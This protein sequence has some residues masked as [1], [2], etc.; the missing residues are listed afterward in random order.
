MHSGKIWALAFQVQD[1]WLD[2]FGDRP[3]FGKQNG[4]DILANKKTFLLV[5]ALTKRR[6][7]ERINPEI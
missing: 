4:G 2:S 6:R 3:Q 5:N 7:E 1:D